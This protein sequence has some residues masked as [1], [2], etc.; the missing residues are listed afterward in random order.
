MVNKNYTGFVELF[1]ER[2]RIECPDFEIHSNGD[3]TTLSERCLNSIFNF[4]T[5]G[6]CNHSCSNP[7]VNDVTI[8]LS[9]L[10]LYA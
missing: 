6:I 7:P 10:P 8:F 9:F 5:N 3:V 2:S 4:I 1:Y